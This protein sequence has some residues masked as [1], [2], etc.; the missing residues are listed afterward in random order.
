MTGRGTGRRLLPLLLLAVLFAQLMGAATAL[1]ATVDEGFHMT[2][3]FEYLRT[4]K[5]RLFDEHPPLVKALFAWPLLP[6]PDLTPP[7]RAPGY[8]DG[9]LIEAAQATVLSYAA[10][11]RLIVACRVPVCLMTVL[12]AAVVYRWAS[13]RFGDLPALAALALFAFD[14]NLLAHGSLATTDMG[15]AL[16]IVGSMM[17]LGAYARQPTLRRWGTAALLLGLAQGAKLTALMLLPLGGVVVLIGAWERPKGA[18]GRALTRAALAYAGMVLAAALVLWALYGFEVRPLADGAVP[19]PAASHVARWQRLRTNLVYGREAFLLGQNRMHGWWQYFPVAFLVKTPL[20]T[21]VLTAIGLPVFAGDLVCAVR[22]RR[23][24]RALALGLFPALYGLASLTSTLNIGYR[25]LLPVLP[26]LYIGIGGLLSGHRRWAEGSP[27]R[28]RTVL[29]ALAAGQ[30]AAALTVAP[31]TLPFFNRIAGGPENG[32]RFLAD[33]NTDWGQTFKVLADYQAAHDLGPVKL[34]SFTFLDPAIYGVD[35]TPIAPMTG[36]PAVLPRRFNP[37]PGLYAISATTLDGVPLPYPATYSGFRHR[38]PF[39]RIGYAMFLYRVEAPAREPGW[40]AQCTA[41]A[42]PL[43]AE[44]IAEGFGASDLREIAFDCTQSWIYPAEGSAPGWYALNTPGIDRLRWPRETEHLA[45]W[46]GWTEGLPRSTLRLS[47]VQQQPGALPPFALWAWQPADLEGAYTP[48]PVALEGGLTFLGYTAPE[49]ATEGGDLTVLTAWRVE[50]VPA[51][52]LSLMLHLR[53]PAGEGLAV[54]DGLGVPIDQ[55]RSG[56]VLV[57][58][59][60][61]AVPR[62]APDRAVLVAGAYW[63]DDVSRLETADGAGE[64]VLTE[65]PIR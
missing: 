49:R 43:T 48:R 7:E 42:P 54:G 50:A 64:F 60:A 61:L 10:I 15:A 32:W 3:G 27:V 44:A 35:Y 51:R 41:P 13:R 20:P 1:S 58:R 30:M 23:A 18:R 47:Y 56:D 21:L 25:H 6:V 22:R 65:V 57:Q 19:L 5:V 55:W 2:S 40:L 29:A 62:P 26:F 38:E 31:H 46:P 33:S 52:P 37:A 59:H 36:A 11:D 34:S 53:S 9:N 24:A 4:G 28:R 12:L 17:A 63:L 39:A 45:W 16:L 8:A 14:P